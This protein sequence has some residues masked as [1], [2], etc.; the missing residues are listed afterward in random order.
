MN[1]PA[2]N[3]FRH[4]KGFAPIV[5]IIVVVVIGVVAVGIASGALKGSFKISKN[6]QQAQQAANTDQT[7]KKAPEE[8]AS[9]LPEIQ[10]GEIYTSPQKDFSLKPPKDWKVDEGQSI[11]FYEGS[12]FKGSPAVLVVTTV[13]LG[14]LKGAQFSTIVDTVRISLKKQY[15]G[16][17]IETDQ[18]TK[19]NGYDAH[20][21]VFDTTQ[22]GITYQVKAYLV[23]SGDNLYN[24]LTVANKESLAKFKQ[25]LEESINTF[26]L[27]NN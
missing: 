13:P 20:L 16:S 3:V 19:V 1:L 17:V 5:L 10:L 22:D 7:T 14:E 18:A 27:L 23:V 15:A 26:K 11:A 12:T 4:K 24:V 9:P 2:Q 6:G 8:K 25:A 21:L